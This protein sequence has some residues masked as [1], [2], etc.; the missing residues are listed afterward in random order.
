MMIE[1]ICVSA[2][3]R[4]SLSKICLIL[5]YLLTRPHS[6]LTNSNTVKLKVTKHFKYKSVY[7]Y[8][9]SSL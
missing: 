6:A 8:V 9:D 2:Q 1:Q 3:Q 5:K 7:I 4:D